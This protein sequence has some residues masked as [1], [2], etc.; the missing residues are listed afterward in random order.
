MLWAVVMILDSS[1]GLSVVFHLHVP[2]SLGGIPV[3]PPHFFSQK[4]INPTI[5]RILSSHS[6]VDNED[7][8]CQAKEA[9]LNSLGNPSKA[10]TL[11]RFIHLLMRYS[12]NLLQ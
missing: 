3:L 4:Y 5:A 6:A 1:L 12:I 2:H 10:A 7:L 8:H 9:L 11:S